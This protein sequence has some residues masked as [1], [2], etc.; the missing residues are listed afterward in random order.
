MIKLYNLAQ[1]EA[2]IC[3]FGGKT[4]HKTSSSWHS[5]Q[6]SDFH[7][8]LEASLTFTAGTDSAVPTEAPARGGTGAQGSE[9]CQCL[10]LGW[11]LANVALE[12]E[13]ERP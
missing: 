10:A 3:L 7:T 4:Y 13:A 5:K 9:G 1:R 11:S 6:K 8:V 12:R 2:N